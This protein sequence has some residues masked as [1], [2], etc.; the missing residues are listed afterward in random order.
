MPNLSR[1]LTGD[2]LFR[3]K[4]N[5]WKKSYS[6]ILWDDIDRLTIDPAAVLGILSFGY[7][8]GER[9]LFNEIKMSPWLSEVKSDHSIDYHAIPD[10]GFYW[11]SYDFIAEELISLLS[12]ELEVV[13]E[14]KKKDNH[15]ING[16]T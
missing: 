9:T 15:I 16:W 8:T 1:H 5:P 4:D 12:K 13:C 2:I 6:S 3:Y 14:G 11:N 7:A 10:H